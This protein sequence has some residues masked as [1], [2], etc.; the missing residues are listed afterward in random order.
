MA[1]SQK[2]QTEKRITQ[3]GVT[4]V[5]NTPLSTDI[6]LQDYDENE[7]GGAWPFRELVGSLMWL[8]HQSRPDISNVFRAVSGFSRNPKQR[9]WKAAR[10]ILEYLNAT[11]SYGV[12]FQRDSGL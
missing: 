8:A 11:S 5:R 12:T 2:S 10:G 9:Y 1:I 3:Y 4:A 7:A 6:F